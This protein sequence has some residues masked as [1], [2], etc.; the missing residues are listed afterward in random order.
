MEVFINSSPKKLSLILKGDSSPS[1]MNL[2]LA[3]QLKPLM[4]QVTNSYVSI[5]TSVIGLSKKGS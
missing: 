4:S 2:S 1:T 3:P 5:A